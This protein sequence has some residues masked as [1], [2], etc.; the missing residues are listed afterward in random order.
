M[1]KSELKAL[2]RETIKEVHHNQNVALL[3]EYY[4]ND[5]KN[6]NLNE[7]VVDFMKHKMVQPIVDFLIKK[8]STLDPETFSVLADAVEEK[9]EA[10]IEAVFS[11]PRIKSAEIEITNQVVNECALLITEEDGQPST[12]KLI[13]NYIK[14][15]PISA[16]GA[17]AILSILGWIIYKSGGVVMLLAAMGA[18]ALKTYKKHERNSWGKLFRNLRRKKMSRDWEKERSRLKDYDKPKNDDKIS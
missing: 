13:Y 4:I 1:K 10:T 7:E 12:I 9:D 8:L 2:I 17:L 18:A 6:A 11:D 16:V 5:I 15:N 3:Q 14:Q